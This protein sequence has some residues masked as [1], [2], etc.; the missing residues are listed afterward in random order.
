[1]D[2]NAFQRDTVTNLQLDYP[3]LS[4]A[5]TYGQHPA[6]A[7]YGVYHVAAPNAAPV[8][9]HAVV[10]VDATGI[11]RAVTVRPEGVISSDEIVV[12]ASVA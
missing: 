9:V 11:V 4:E 2:T 8:A 3:L 10:V 7:A 5:P 1:M 6:S 12:A